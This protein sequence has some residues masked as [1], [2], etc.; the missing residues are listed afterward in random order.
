MFELYNDFDPL[1]INIIVICFLPTYLLF[2]CSLCFG[3]SS[4]LLQALYQLYF[5]PDMER[6]NVAQKWLAQ[7]QA[8]A[9][10]WQ[11]CWALL[12]PDK[13]GCY[14]SAQTF[15]QLQN[16]YLYFSVQVHQAE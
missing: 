2:K 12:G 6:K 9:Q 1:L 11:F 15:L 7:A 5:D 8:S 4:L 16:L 3:S 13:V 10:A 14:G